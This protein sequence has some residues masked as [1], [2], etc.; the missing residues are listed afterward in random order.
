MKYF[1]LFLVLFSTAVFAQDNSSIPST[2]IPRA[3]T[4]MPKPDE[5][6]P[7]YSIS[8]PFIPE[9]FKTP[10]KFEPISM[11][12]P[13]QIKPQVSDLNPGLAYE[14]KL[15]KKQGEGSSDSKLFRRNQNFGQFKTESETLAIS[16]L[17][18]QAV[19]G[20]MIRVWID[21]KVVIDR[22]V[23]E[24]IEKRIY[25]GLIMGINFIQIEAINEGEFSPNTGE[26]ALI[27][28]EKYTLTAGEWGLSTGFKATFNVER[29]P[30]GSLLG[31][32]KAI[33]K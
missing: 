21:G 5:G 33:N 20:D 4:N 3:E 25:I 17:D 16:Y 30:K 22:I 19:D 13:M 8:K 26:F 2:S 23:L 27:D 1:Y 15:N 6:T 11:D 32:K 14:K 10:Q 7:Q 31:N 18:F 12:K 28:E 24:G 29:V 9:R